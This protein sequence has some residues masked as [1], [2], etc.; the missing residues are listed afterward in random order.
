MRNGVPDVPSDTIT[1]LRNLRSWLDLGKRAVTDIRGRRN[2]GATTLQNSQN[3]ADYQVLCNSIAAWNLAPLLHSHPGMARGF[4]ALAYAAEAIHADMRA[5]GERPAPR[6]L[7]AHVQRLYVLQKI[8]YD[9]KMA[10]V[11]LETTPDCEGKL[12]PRQITIT[13]CELTTLNLAHKIHGRDPAQTHFTR[14][15]VLAMKGLPGQTRCTTCRSNTCPD[16]VAAFHNIERPLKAPPAKRACPPAP[17][18]P[19]ITVLADEA[20][21]GPS[22][23]APAPVE[24]NPPFLCPDSVNPTHDLR[25]FLAKIHRVTTSVWEATAEIDHPRRKP[26]MRRALKLIRRWEQY[27]SNRKRPNGPEMIRLINLIRSSVCLFVRRYPAW[28]SYTD[29]ATDV[30]SDDPD[31]PEIPTPER[32]PPRRLHM[33]WEEPAARAAFFAHQAEGAEPMRPEKT[34]AAL[35]AFLDSSAATTA[36]LD[37]P[38]VPLSEYALKTYRG[39]RELIGQWTDYCIDHAGL[40][41]TRTLSASVNEAYKVL[42]IRQHREH[43]A[44]AIEMGEHPCTN[45]RHRDFNPDRWGDRRDYHVDPIHSDH[46]GTIQFLGESGSSSDESD[47]SEANPALSPIVR[48]SANGSPAGFRTPDTTLRSR[49]ASTLSTPRTPDH[50]STSIMTSDTEFNFIRHI[51]TPACTHPLYTLLNGDANEVRGAVDDA[52]APATT[53]GTIR[54]VLRVALRYLYGYKV[55]QFFAERL[56]RNSSWE[57]RCLETHWEMVTRWIASTL[58]GPLG[59]TDDLNAFMKPYQDNDL[60]DALHVPEGHPDPFAVPGPDRRPMQQMRAMLEIQCLAIIAMRGVAVT[61]GSPPSPNGRAPGPRRMAPR[62]VQALI[63]SV[64]LRWASYRRS[65]RP[66]STRDC[67]RLTYMNDRL[68]TSL[69]TLQIEE[70]HDFGPLCP[71]TDIAC[72]PATEHILPT[73]HLMNPE[74]DAGP[75]SSTR[76]ANCRTA[77]YH[78][79]TPRALDKEFA[80][81]ATGASTPDT[82]HKKRGKR[83]PD[84][85]EDVTAVFEEPATRTRNVPLARLNVLR[86]AP[87]APRKPVARRAPQQPHYPRGPRMKETLTCH[88]EALL[89]WQARLSRRPPTVDDIKVAER[90]NDAWVIYLASTQPLAVG[91]LA[92]LDAVVQTEH[93]AFVS[94]VALAKIPLAQ[95]QPPPQPA[96]KPA[97]YASLNA[98]HAAVRD[99]NP[100][101][102]RASSSPQLHRMTMDEQ[103]THVAQTLTA[104]DGPLGRRIKERIDACRRGIATELRHAVD[105]VLERSATMHATASQ[106]P[107]ARLYVIDRLPDAEPPSNDEETSQSGTSTS[108]ASS[109]TS[110]SSGGPGMAALAHLPKLYHT[111][112][113]LSEDTTESS[114]E[115]ALEPTLQS[116]PAVP[117]ITPD[118]RHSSPDTLPGP[119][120]SSGPGVQFGPPTRRADKG[121]AGS[122]N[123]S[124]AAEADEPAVTHGDAVP[125]QPTRPLTQDERRMLQQDMQRFAKSVRGK[126]PP[127]STLRVDTESGR[128]MCDQEV[129][130]DMAECNDDDGTL[131]PR[132]VYYLTIDAQQP[133]IN[134]VFA[135]LQSPLRGPCPSRSPQAKTVTWPAALKIMKRGIWAKYELGED[136]HERCHNGCCKRFRLI[137]LMEHVDACLRAAIR[138][139]QNAAATEAWLKYAMC[140]PG[141]RASRPYADIARLRI[142]ASEVMVATRSDINE[143]RT[144]LAATRTVQMWCEENSETSLR[145]SD[146]MLH[147]VLCDEQVSDFLSRCQESV[148]WIKC[149]AE[150]VADC[151]RRQNP[152]P[153][154]EVAYFC[155]VAAGDLYAN[156]HSV[157]VAIERIICRALWSDDDKKALVQ[158]ERSLP[159]AIRAIFDFLACAGSRIA[160][161]IASDLRRADACLLDDGIMAT[162]EANRRW[163]LNLEPNK[164]YDLIH[165]VSSIIVRLVARYA[166]D[167]PDVDGNGARMA[168][169]EIHRELFS[170]AFARLYEPLRHFLARLDQPVIVYR[171]DAPRNLLSK[172]EGPV[173]YRVDQLDD[174]GQPID[175][176]Q[177]PAADRPKCSDMFR[178]PRDPVYVPPMHEGKFIP[179]GQATTRIGWSDPA[180]RA[181]I[182][183]E[184]RECRRPL[185]PG[186]YFPL[187]G[188]WIAALPFEL[189]PKM[190]QY[191]PAYPDDVP[192]DDTYNLPP[193][194]V[195]INWQRVP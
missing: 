49:D 121:D 79:P 51:P 39:L 180:F 29:G 62:H 179:V 160:R 60:Q 47:D 140:L 70:R 11:T 20:A 112:S 118:S 152:F 129:P 194:T 134:E 171:V 52:K 111:S 59:T 187:T 77:H 193:A 116:A 64:I 71:C 43:H 31:A 175:P 58:R 89:S 3:R 149:A 147:H 42:R 143:L 91:D 133:A 172:R 17:P 55:Y 22:T 26:R 73:S 72:V 5:P 185:C 93:D 7:P 106:S 67:V 127:I 151:M 102:H 34:L 15:P 177:A 83:T 183:A 44:E 54:R 123:E 173:F 104:S 75:S 74:D 103:L 90:F 122:D 12:P 92:A 167:G 148:T 141:K 68:V 87:P 169:N 80:A 27:V 19:V 16:Q 114:A 168:E 23:R 69:R 97:R 132:P 150:A 33:P 159:P 155:E 76:D 188:A 119:A 24:R 14:N 38:H 164:M 165:S 182:Y 65:H 158:L 131:T 18:R 190:S 32:N 181:S 48:T 125:P 139:H 78:L 63:E 135:D 25:Q 50:G 178:P 184:L 186:E 195:M 30:D 21:P 146:G 4:S 176:C 145:G 156:L 115:T 189:G 124:D 109:S 192:T 37:T 56:G 1:R 84:F 136:P 113:S 94:Q 101:R 162:T 137:S 81:G 144:S 10:R 96:A 166:M 13:P 45:S 28:R 66:S 117:E 46:T 61:N 153:L 105:G 154:R 9:D 157:R 128:C 161:P 36:L 95:N 98:L 170:L 85:S 99:P 126:R 174:A 163:R 35:R 138:I 142:A 88:Y 108:S 100:G 57:W 120:S 40:N 86:K 8:V 53:P 130:T 2:Q 110:S 191:D 6:P 107:R 41:A 82:G